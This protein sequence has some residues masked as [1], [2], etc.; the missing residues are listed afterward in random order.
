[1]RDNSKRVADV[2]ALRGFALLG[3]LQVNILAFSSVFYGT[4]V[5]SPMASAASGQL[6]AIVVSIVFEL[7]FY[8][9]FSFLFGY[10]FTLQLHSAVKEGRS[11]M[12]RFLRRQAGLLVIGALHAALLFHGDI[13]TTYAGLGLGLLVVRDWTDR[14]LSRI[15]ISLILCSAGFWVVVALL[16]SVFAEPAVDM[17][18]AAEN[19]SVALKAYRGSFGDVISQHILDV[20]G[21]I[22]L[23]LLVQA[24]CAFAMFLCG[25]IAGRRQLLARAEIYLPYLQRLI[26]YGLSVGVPGAVLYALST[27][28]AAGTSWETAGLAISLLTAP[29]LA[30]A[31]IALAL[32]AFDKLRGG[33]LYIGL[34]NA[35]RMALSNYLTQSIVCGLVFYGYGLGQI[36]RL[37]L[38]VVSAFA[39]MIFIGQ[40]V[41]STLWFRKFRYG[42]IEWILRSITL[43]RWA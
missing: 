4:G 26:F 2:D 38:P 6:W 16:Q 23:L 43:G 10:S 5:P 9:L 31:Y 32:C 27:H 39:W 36:D 33:Y 7:K 8:L 40:L 11:F 19:A 25:Y 42:P 28:M 22:P 3:I 1:M 41:A 13:L 29:L 17:Q 35:G 21:A 12:P 20:R 30:A 14:T 15:A 24:P 37:P 18:V 34:A